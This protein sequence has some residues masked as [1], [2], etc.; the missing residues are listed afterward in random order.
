[1]CSSDLAAGDAEGVLFEEAAAAADA[2]PKPDLEKLPRRT[3]RERL[4]QGQGTPADDPADIPEQSAGQ[5]AQETRQ[6]RSRDIQPAGEAA[7]AGASQP[8]TAV[9]E[10]TG[11]SRRTRRTR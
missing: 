4:E 10:G 8:E 7:A 11:R 9:E 6:R 5:P 2:V 3:R 1:M